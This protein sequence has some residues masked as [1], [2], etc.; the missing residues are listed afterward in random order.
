MPHLPT[1]TDLLRTTVVGPPCAQLPETFRPCPNTRH[2]SVAHNSHYDTPLPSPT[3]QTCSL[4][5]W[6]ARRWVLP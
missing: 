5:L 1:T 6:W 4:P 3:L 2:R